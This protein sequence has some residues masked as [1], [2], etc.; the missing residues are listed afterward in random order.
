MLANVGRSC[1]VQ[2]IITGRRNV[3]DGKMIGETS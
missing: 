2:E 1:R 3:V